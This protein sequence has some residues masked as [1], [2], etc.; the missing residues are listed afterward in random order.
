MLR[1]TWILL[2]CTSAWGSPEALATPSIKL[3]VANS[4]ADDIS[5][6]D[7]NSLK[8]I[9]NIKV[10]AHVHGVAAQADGRRL[11]TTVESDNTLKI[12]DTA[13]DQIIDTIKLTGRPNQCA[14]T[15]NGRYV[16]VPIR[17]D[18]A[19]DIVEVVQRRVVKVLP[20]K[21]PCHLQQL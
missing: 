16:V 17:D 10:G 6:I 21:M 1:L 3:Y 9:R 12:I 5:V 8:V 11:F 20:V 7:L 18:N 14:V 2:A 15:P 4:A 13:N 19:V